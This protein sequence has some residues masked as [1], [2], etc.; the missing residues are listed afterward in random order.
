M[1]QKRQLAAIMFTDIEGYTA[2]M[3]Q[4]EQQALALKNR[5]REVLQRCH[6]QYN[7]RIVQYY[8]DGALSMF[9]SAVNA[10]E[11]ALAMQLAYRQVPQVPVRMGLHMG[12]VVFDEEQLFGDGVNLASRVESLG[13]AGSV[14]IS[15]KIRDEVLNHPN[16]KTYSVGAYQF[17]NVERKV[18]VFALDHEGLVRPAPDSLNGKTEV[19]K[20][21]SLRTSKRPPPKSIAVLPLVNMSNDPEQ[22]YFSDGIAEEII[23]SLSN[24]KDL[25][26]AGRTSSFRFDRNNVDLRE[27]GEKLG[28]STVLEGSVRK[29]GERFRIT[30]QLTKVEDGFHIWSER[31]DGDM[32][33]IFAVQDQIATE[34]TEKMKVTLL[35]K[36]KSKLRKTSTHNSEAYELYLKGRFYLN[37]RGTYILTGITYLQQAIKLDPD[38]ALAHAEY[39]DANLMAG[40]Y[41]LVPPNKVMLKAR[42]SAEMALKLNPLLCETYCALGS[43]YC[44]V[45][46]LPEAERHFL[47]SLELNPSYAPAHVRYGLNYLAWIKGDFA[48][49]E[50]HGRKAIKL[51]PLSAICFGIYAQ[52]L[53]TA[54]KFEEALE[55]CRTGLELDGSSFLCLLYEGYSYLFMKQYEKALACFERLM[56]LSDR[57]NFVHG[58]LVMTLSK[59]GDLERARLE[60]SNLKERAEKEYI[61]CTVIGI[62]AGWVNDSLDEAFHYF[63]RGYRE[64]DPLLVSL[65]HE[66][67]VSDAVRADPRY[68][69]LLE[70]MNSPNVPRSQRG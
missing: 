2:I 40:L 54:G 44:Y 47:K 19:K 28:V 70:K 38:F 13:V 69:R 66:H 30:V 35:G 52:I 36:G 23:N 68:Q 48:K 7:G 14:L 65:R 16:I 58:A 9:Q 31:Y 27:V 43:Y 25:K 39:A 12:D 17:K 21:A 61:V 63:E 4:N 45:W 29:Q 24:L 1:S 41:G 37:R 42:R 34:I 49:A 18:E 56:V 5:H 15:D 20:K 51:E 26:V 60:L 57:H 62:A 55:A 8:G 3:Q 11:C 32:H 64:H 22:Q 6:Q 33:D 67:W 53:H 50:E 59:M 10:V 46:D